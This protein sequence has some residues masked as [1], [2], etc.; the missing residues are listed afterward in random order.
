MTKEKKEPKKITAGLVFSW[1]F[2]LIFM[3]V[4]L[5]MLIQSKVVAGIFFI[6]AGIII[7]PA[8]NKFLKKKV[9][10]VLSKWLIFLIMVICLIV[11][12][13]TMSEPSPEYI[14]EAGEISSIPTYALG[15]SFTLGNFKYTLNSVEQKSKIIGAMGYLTKEGNFLIVDLTLENIG[16]EAEYVNDEIYIIDSLAREFESNHE[17]S[18]YLDNY[19][20]SIDKINPTLSQTGQ[21]VFEVPVDIIGKVGIKKSMWTDKFSAFVQYN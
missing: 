14:D 9:N 3:F 18:F 11:A 19:L 2:S 5:G 17:L 12:F 1:I 16:E 10:L 15:E 8:F 7:D 13:S 4:G 20:S 21:L 6:L